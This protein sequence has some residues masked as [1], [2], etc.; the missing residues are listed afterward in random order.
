MHYIYTVLSIVHLPNMR[1]TISTGLLKCC[2]AAMNIEGFD[3]KIIA[4]KL[5]TIPIQRKDHGDTPKR[6]STYPTPWTGF[7]THKIG[8]KYSI[9]PPI[10]GKNQ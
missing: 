8:S 4:G 2:Y 10:K 5:V 7:E 3:K 1:C 6:L 9:I